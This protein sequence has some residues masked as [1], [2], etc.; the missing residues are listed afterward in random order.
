MPLRV[1]ANVFD[2]A[3]SKCDTFFN[4]ALIPSQASA[5]ITA[6]LP[7]TTPAGSA[8]LHVGSNAAVNNFVAGPIA[9]YLIYNRSLTTLER[10]RVETYLARKWGITLAPQVANAEAQ[11]WVN[12]VYANGGTVSTSTASAVSTFCDAIESAGIRDR[13]Y[14]LNLFCGDNLNAA[15]V[16]LYRNSSLLLSGLGSATDA[17]PGAGPFV[18]G[19]YSPTV[20]LFKSGN[21]SAYLDTGLATDALPT[22][23]TGHL[24]AWMASHTPTGFLYAL[25]ADTGVSQRY[26]LVSRVVSSQAVVRTQWGQNQNAETA[27]LGASMPAGL[28]IGNRASST[29]LNIYQ[30][31][32]SL[33]SNTS[34]TTPA[35][36]SRTFYVAALNNDGSPASFANFP[37]AGYSI[38]ASLTLQQATDYDLAYKALIAALGRPLT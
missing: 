22:A 12:R 10:Q 17:N 15:L 14:R 37:I 16:P 31:G 35:A 4:S 6:A 28:Y 34:S 29:A 8:T 1:Y 5:Y 11:D 19:D 20:G 25:G 30:D 18:S 33:A 32:T 23:A 38:G 7:A 24:A 9:E 13:F 21:T 2:G 27:G 26:W 3:A 36:I